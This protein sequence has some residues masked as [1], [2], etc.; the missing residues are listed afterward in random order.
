MEIKDRIVRFDRVPASSLKASPRNWRDHPEAQREALRAVLG[1]VGVADAALVREL[2]DGSLELIDG[3]LRTE[4]LGDGLIPILVLDVDEVEANKILLTHDPLA[5]MAKTDATK[6]DSLLR[7]IS[8]NTSEL[9]SLLARIAETEGIKPPNFKAADPAS[10][11]R[12]DQPKTVS[13]PN[14]DYV[15]TP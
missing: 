4:E 13:C 6:L 5:A 10:Q 7:D 11:G 1:D 2:P 15:F 9:D 8:S 14:C 12:L 3:H